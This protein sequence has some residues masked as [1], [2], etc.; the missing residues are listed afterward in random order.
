MFAA[1][2]QHV[3]SIDIP[4][5]RRSVDWY[6]FETYQDLWGDIDRGDTKTRHQLSHHYNTLPRNK[7]CSLTL[8]LF[9]KITGRR[10]QMFDKMTKDKVLPDSFFNEEQEEYSFDDNKW[11]F[12]SAT[13]NFARISNKSIRKAVKVMSKKLL[14]VNKPS[15]LTS[16]ITHARYLDEFLSASK[17]PSLAK[18][19]TNHKNNFYNYLI[20][21]EENGE[22]SKAH[23]LLRLTRK[24]YTTLNTAEERK[25]IIAPDLN[26]PKTEY[27]VSKKPKD[28]NYPIL[29][30]SEMQ[31]ILDYLV[32]VRKMAPSRRI[33]RTAIILQ[34]ILSRR[35]SE[36]LGLETD[37]IVFLGNSGEW[38]LKYRTSKQNAIKKVSVSIL[39]G[40]RQDPFAL[41]MR[42]LVPE[43]VQEV[44]D[45]TRM[46]RGLA[47]KEIRSKLFIRHG[48]KVSKANPVMVETYNQIRAEWGTI[49]EQLDI[50]PRITLH[51]SR[52]TTATLLLRTGSNYAQAGEALGDTAN[53]IKNN[54][55]ATISKLETMSLARGHL[56]GDIESDVKK[57]V[58]TKY[59]SPSPI[60]DVE[61]MN[62]NTLHKVC[63]GNCG[64]S[65]EKMYAC[66]TYLMTKGGSGCKGCPSFFPSP[67]NL[68]YWIMEQRSDYGNMQKA[69]GTPLHKR[70]KLNYLRTEN[71]V[72]TLK[73]M[74][75]G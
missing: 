42:D 46:L 53:T 2:K 13:M 59:S 67:I 74:S 56:I 68:P 22:H 44:K 28:Y 37:C 14:K 50:N 24:L 41:R 51:K 60:S 52:H 32:K 12:D 9:R 25:D 75:N 70:H 61:A 64:A 71:L 26:F 54:Y 66:E 35:P 43:L 19:T 55:S 63:G 62:S 27:S 38:L 34:L 47:P 49:K 69:K 31:E 40:Y 1:Y 45:L 39:C 11:S 10:K 8:E 36:T 16:H 6:F 7:P 21:L 73:E 30:H 23:G 57:I 17:I 5:E 3:K 29:T 48:Y 18:F 72:K 33:T 4:I 65:Q 58:D 20:K 15:T